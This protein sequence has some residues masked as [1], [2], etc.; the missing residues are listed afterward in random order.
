M[1]RMLGRN[2]HTAHFCM[3]GWKCRCERG[4]ANAHR[5][6]SGK[7]VDASRRQLRRRE[8]V[9]WRADA[10]YELDEPGRPARNRGWN[11]VVLCGCG[12]GRRD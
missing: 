1:A 11:G 9:S 2:G 4:K 12:C 10:E 5:R 3:Y 6:N 7:T 8:D